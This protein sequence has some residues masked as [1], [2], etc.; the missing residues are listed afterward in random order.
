MVLYFKNKKPSGGFTMATC[1]SVWITKVHG[2]DPVLGRQLAPDPVCF[3]YIKFVASA[4]IYKEK[5]SIIQ[6]HHIIII[7][8]T[9][10]R[11]TSFLRHAYFTYSNFCRYTIF[12][13]RHI[14]VTNNDFQ[15]LLLFIII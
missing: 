10:T 3:R 7:I 4:L 1:K 2:F 9:F 13:Y 11:L 14:F 8:I 6:S 12:V 5:R 15:E